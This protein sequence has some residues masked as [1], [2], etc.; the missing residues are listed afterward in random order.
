MSMPGPR[1]TYED[2]KLLPED[3]RY[4]I[5]EGDLFMTPAPNF[6]HQ[7][8]LSR[9]LVRLWTF[10]EAGGLGQVVPAP[11]DVILS[12]ENVVQPDLLFVS[13]ERLGIVDQ[14]GGV[15]GAPDLA[16]EIL[17]QSTLRRDQIIKRK[18]YSKYGVREYWVVDPEGRAVEILTQTAT[19]LET[20]RVFPVGS[21]VTS[22]LLPGLSISTSDVFAD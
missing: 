13:K 16:V 14:N 21:V 5:I 4:E 20:W 10:V 7:M 6:R 11:T 22:P 12:Q 17:S 18:L 19:G 15:G 8:I 2:Y 3:K 9:L 1:F